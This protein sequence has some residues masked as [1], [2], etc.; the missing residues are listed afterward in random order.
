MTRT[1]KFSPTAWLP[2]A[3]EK[4]YDAAKTL[5][6]VRRYTSAHTSTGRR[7]N[8]PSE[9]LPVRVLSCVVVVCVDSLI[10]NESEEY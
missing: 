8:T 6:P 7:I 4:E 3:G 1:V 9:P 2:L 5:W 10:P